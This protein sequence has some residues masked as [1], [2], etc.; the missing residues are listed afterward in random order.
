M[1]FIGDFAKFAEIQQFR[2]IIEMKHRLVAA[3]FAV[4]RHVLA[5]IHVLKVIRNIAAIAALD[6]LSELFDDLRV[7]FRHRKIVLE[8][9]GNFKRFSQRDEKR[10]V[11]GLN[12]AYRIRL[13]NPS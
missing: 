6:A 9:R 7:V 5:E 11:C 4:I 12:Q 13:K 1:I 8:S 10:Q 3:V 2:K